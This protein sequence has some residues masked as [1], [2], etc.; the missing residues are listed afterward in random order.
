MVN[1]QSSDAAEAVF[2]EAGLSEL[3]GYFF[4]CRH[5]NHSHGASTLAYTVNYAAATAIEDA[6]MKHCCKNNYC[7]IHITKK[8]G[9]CE[10][11]RGAKQRGN[12]KKSIFLC[13]LFFFKY[14]R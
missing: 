10:K 9:D 11:K 2:A 12:V 4:P 6:R 3:K 5:L 13:K 1:W 14:Q 8:R 7:L